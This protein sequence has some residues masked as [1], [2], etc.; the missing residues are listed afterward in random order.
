MPFPRRAAVFAFCALWAA[1]APGFAQRLQLP[2][3]TDQTWF[4]IGGGFIAMSPFS[5]PQPLIII[6]IGGKGIE[7]PL[8]IPTTGSEVFGMQCLGSHLELLV[9]ESGSDHFSVLPFHVQP[10]PIEREQ[11]EDIDWSISQK[12]SMPPAIE[13]RLEAF[14]GP[15][16]LPGSTMWG[17]WYEEV[18]RV[19]NT[20]HAYEV[21]FL[22]RQTGDTI[23]VVV[24]LLEETFTRK[25]TR[26]ISLIRAKLVDVKD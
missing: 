1:T 23:R 10:G 8:T 14:H 9:R 13:R 2:L 15:G 18:P 6:K 22:R 20:G 17:D 12:P 4:C 11:R 26:S 21:H 25:A 19:D 16:S 24:D 3:L 5:R 7:A